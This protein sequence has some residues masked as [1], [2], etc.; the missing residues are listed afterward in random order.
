MTGRTEFAPGSPKRSDTKLGV[1]PRDG[2]SSTPTM[3]LTIMIGIR[4][5]LSVINSLRSIRSETRSQDDRE[6]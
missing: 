2:I 1:A 4:K 6:Q 5:I 3:L